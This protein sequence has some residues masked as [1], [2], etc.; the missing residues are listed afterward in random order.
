MKFAK[1]TLPIVLDDSVK[2]DSILLTDV[3]MS[4]YNNA[5]STLPDCLNQNRSDKHYES[6]SDDGEKHPLVSRKGQRTWAESDLEDDDED[7]DFD[8]QSDS[9]YT[10]SYVTEFTEDSLTGALDNR[11][12]T[13]TTSSL[14]M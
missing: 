6:D 9:R 12:T 2:E 11:V 8:V 3:G 10:S 4:I 7:E 14:F 13:S 1:D 5:E